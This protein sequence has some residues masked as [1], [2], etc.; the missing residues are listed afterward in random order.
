MFQLSHVFSLIIF[1][2]FGIAF[3]ETKTFDTNKSSTGLSLYPK[4]NISSVNFGIGSLGNKKTSLGLKESSKNMSSLKFNDKLMIASHKK[5]IKKTALNK[6]IDQCIGGTA[7]IENFVN[8]IKDKISKFN[9]ERNRIGKSEENRLK[10]KL[11]NEIVGLVAMGFDK[12]KPDRNCFLVNIVLQN[13]ALNIPSLSQ[14]V[15]ARL[16][17]AQLKYK[18][19]ESLKIVDKNAY[20]A[21]TQANLSKVFKSNQS[22]EYSGLNEV[23]GNK[24]ITNGVKYMSLRRHFSKKNK[25]LYSDNN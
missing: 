22:F 11:N 1:F 3:A 9:N 7:Q 6:Q 24:S 4:R 14:E 8:S 2:S 19:I 13:I 23:V 10:D 21:I 15:K 20:I 5:E 25:N 18:Q 17:K 16:I 12:A